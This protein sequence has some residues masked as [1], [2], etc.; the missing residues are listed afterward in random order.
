VGTWE[1]ATWAVRFYERH[2][3]TL[4]S[5]DEKNQLLQEYWN[6]PRR[7][8]ETSVVLK[9]RLTDGVKLPEP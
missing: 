1:D 7:Q 4:V 5:R 8:I 3:F 6:I 9:K 2:G